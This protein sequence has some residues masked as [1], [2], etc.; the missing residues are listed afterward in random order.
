MDQLTENLLQSFHTQTNGYATNDES[1]SSG[2][3]SINLDPL[4]APSSP[5]PNFILGP[6]QQR[7]RLLSCIAENWPETDVYSS[8]PMDDHDVFDT[9]CFNSD[10]LNVDEI[11]SFA[12]E[13]EDATDFITTLD[14]SCILDIESLEDVRIISSPNR[15]SMYF[16]AVND[17]QRPFSSASTFA[18]TN[19]PNDRSQTQSCYGKLENVNQIDDNNEQTNTINDICNDFIFLN[20][21]FNQSKC[22]T[23]LPLI[24]SFHKSFYDESS[25]S[26]NNSINEQ[27]HTVQLHGPHNEPP[28]IVTP[29]IESHN[30]TK[31]D[32]NNDKLPDPILVATNAQSQIN[33]ENNDDGK[34]IR[35][36]ESINLPTNFQ[37]LNATQKLIR[38]NTNN[39]FC[40]IQL[41]F[42]E[43][44]YYIGC[45]FNRLLFINFYLNRRQRQQ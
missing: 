4:T 22:R 11:N 41:I 18:Q 6:Y 38:L 26:H 37:H 24:S 36:N 44:F 23:P 31:G 27:Q 33:A 3:S 19:I 25:A 21:A 9:D 32:D 17:V 13:T 30:C 40:F 42:N 35:L 45:A 15:N 5:E 43:L 39:F 29:T 2:P 20:P 8:L 10:R 34:S 28:D 7:R 12:C 16:T 1:F 14:E